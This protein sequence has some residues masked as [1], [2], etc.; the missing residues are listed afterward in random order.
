MS[1][2]RSLLLYRKMVVE[3]WGSLPVVTTVWGERELSSPGWP[4]EP[5]GG[6]AGL[7]RRQL[8]PGQCRVRRERERERETTI[9]NI[10][11]LRAAA[12][13]GSAGAGAEADQ[14]SPTLE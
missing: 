3:G 13:G 8:S 2:V 4:G 10:E 14:P 9:V 12:S 1:S 6:S 7:R 11:Q 5:L